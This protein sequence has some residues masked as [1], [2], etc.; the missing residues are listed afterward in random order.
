MTQELS[1]TELCPLCRKQND[2][3]IAKDSFTEKCWCFKAS[4]PKEIFD[5]LPSESEKVCICQNCLIRFKASR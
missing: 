5:L 2:C 4:F 3:C 1:E